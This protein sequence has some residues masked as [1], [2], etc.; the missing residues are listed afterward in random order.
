L[1]RCQPRLGHDLVRHHDTTGPLPLLRPSGVPT[2]A[3]SDGSRT[4]LRRTGVP[5]K[6]WKK[7]LSGETML[8]WSPL[9][10]HSQGRGALHCQTESL[11]APAPKRQMKGSRLGYEETNQTQAV[12]ST[13]V[14]MQAHDWSRYDTN[15][16]DTSFTEYCCQHTLRAV[17]VHARRHIFNLLYESAVC[18]LYIGTTA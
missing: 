13:T 12:Q 4:D 16:S 2:W 6:S 15:Q 10:T 5:T 3:S 8:T 9:S 1:A 7:S 18:P 14:K 11:L 17:R